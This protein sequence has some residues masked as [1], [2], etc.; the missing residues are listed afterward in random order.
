MFF[1]AAASAA[2]GLL[3]S[4]ECATNFNWMCTNVNGKQI[5]AVFLRFLLFIMCWWHVTVRDLLKTLLHWCSKLFFVAITHESVVCH[6]KIVILSF[7][8]HFLYE[9]ECVRVFR[10]HLTLCGPNK[11]KLEL[12]LFSFAFGM[13]NSIAVR[14]VRQIQLISWLL[15]LLPFVYVAND[16]T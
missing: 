5:S 3:M 6:L 10:R 13:C 11:L 16:F 1:F 2:A 12:C 8:L 14:P 9:S 4:S 15:S 7:R